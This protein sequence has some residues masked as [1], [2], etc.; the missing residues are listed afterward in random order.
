MSDRT[1][2]NDADPTAFAIRSGGLAGSQPLPYG[3][4]E[5]AGQQKGGGASD[6]DQHHSEGDSGRTRVNR[7][8]DQV[9]EPGPATEDGGADD[10]VGLAPDTGAGE[11]ET[12]LK[13]PCEHEHERLGDA[14][15]GPFWTRKF[16]FDVHVDLQ[17]VGGTD[18]T[19]GTVQCSIHHK[20]SFVNN[21]H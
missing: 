16:L 3:G 10:S 9:R 21:N 7:A 12:E 18:S 20:S 14:E 6:D 8:V 19:G 13:C 17:V 11:P 15:D 5:L 2:K 1:F 4:A